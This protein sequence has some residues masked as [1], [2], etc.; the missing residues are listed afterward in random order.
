[1]TS[2]SGKG[3]FAYRRAVGKDAHSPLAGTD[4][5]LTARDKPF[6]VGIEGYLHFAKSS[7]QHLVGCMAR[8][9]RSLDSDTLSQYPLSPSPCR[10]LQGT[11]LDTRGTE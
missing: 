1:M 6:D 10:S 5:L 9:E 4:W 2:P 11:W 3:D 8:C 7:G